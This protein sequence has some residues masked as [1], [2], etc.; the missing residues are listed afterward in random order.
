MTIA[1]SPWGGQHQP[2]SILS[3]ITYTPRAAKSWGTQSDTGSVFSDCCDTSLYG[4]LT[5]FRTDSLS[6]AL[7]KNDPTKFIQLLS[8][9]LSCFWC[10]S[11]LQVVYQCVTCNIEFILQRLGWFWPQ[12]GHLGWW[13]T[14]QW[15]YAW[16]QQYTEW[17]VYIS[18]ILHRKSTLGYSCAHERWS[19]TYNT[20]YLTFIK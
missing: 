4:S 12:A 9:S 7:E 19:K 11:L 18:G 13:C 20:F 1:Q 16:M 17:K 5:K 15:H 2:V 14:I 6:K 8:F 10:M 3:D